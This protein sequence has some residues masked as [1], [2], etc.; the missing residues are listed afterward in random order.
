MGARIDTALQLFTDPE[1]ATKLR[2]LLGQANNDEQAQLSARIKGSTDLYG[3]L[4]KIQREDDNKA[5]TTLLNFVTKLASGLINTMNN[6]TSNLAGAFGATFPQL[7]F[8]NIKRWFGLR[9]GGIVNVPGKGVPIGGNYYAGEAGAEAVLPLND[10]TFEALGRA[11]ARN[12]TINTTLI[13]QM[14]GR[15]LSRELLKV[16]SDQDFA[17]NG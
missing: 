4:F 10:S 15:T 13:N 12:M 17:S 6:I 5:K 7:S 3:Q 11:I 8:T 16:M 2:T 1:E 9:E 14:N